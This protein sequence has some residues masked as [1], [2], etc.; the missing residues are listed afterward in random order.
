MKKPPEEE[1]GGFLNAKSR[2]SEKIWVLVAGSGIIVNVDQYL[3]K[4]YMKRGFLWN[5]F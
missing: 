4:F 5:G 1:L 3:E 2:I